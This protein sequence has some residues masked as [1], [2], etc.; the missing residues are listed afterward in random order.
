MVTEFERGIIIPV[1]P[2][3]TKKMRSDMQN[4]FLIGFMGAGKSTVAGWL[5]S[6]QGMRLVEMDQ[7]IVQKEQMSISEIFET[8]GESYF[9]CLETGLL[10][11]LQDQKDTVVSCGGGVPMRQCNVDAMRRSGVVV[12]LSAEPET[13]YMRVKNNHDR[14]LLEG[15]MTVEY[16]SGLLEKRLPAYLAAADVTVKT[17]GRE[18]EEI[19]LEILEKCREK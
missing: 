15:N 12:Y 10:E 5:N 1:M 17:D 8:K 9:R 4:I 16:I 18:V 2:L 11:E 14:P 19:C 13:V 6:R 7:Q 3:F